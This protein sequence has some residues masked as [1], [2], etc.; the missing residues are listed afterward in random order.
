MIMKQFIIFLLLTLF[1]HAQNY[2][3]LFAQLGTPLYKADKTFIKISKLD[4][5]IKKMT[6]HYHLKVIKLRKLAN[7]IE[8]NPKDSKKDKKRYI[9]ELRQLQKDYDEITR[10]V[11]VYLF[12]SIDA[13]DYKEF[14]HIM[15]IGHDIFLENNIIKKRAM[16]YYV[17][18][19]TR[20]KIPVLD[21]SYLTLKSDPVLYAYVKGYM[22][23]THLI[24][25]RYS[26]GGIAHKVLLSKDQKTAFMG[27]GNYCFKS[28]DIRN[29]TNASQ[30]ASFDFH[31][32]SCELVDMQM[33]ASGKYLFLSDL[34]NGFTV[35]DITQ[36]RAPLQKD[37]WTKVQALC[38]VTSQD[39][40]TSFVVKKDRGLLVLDIYNKDEFRLLANYNKGLQ[41]NHLA[42]DDN[43]SKLY[44]AHSKGL[45]V[46][47]VSVL[48]NP[49]EIYSFPIKNGANHIILDPSKKLAYVASGDDGV[50]VL[51]LSKKDQISLIST[52]LTP[53]YAYHLTLSNSG[54]KLFV[55]ALND[56]VYYI[57]T[58]NSKDLKHVSTYKLD[59]AKA[60]ALSATL[61]AKEDTLFIAYGKLGM[62]KIRLK[63]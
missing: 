50:H 43:N 31:A 6:K 33:S 34:K 1:L 60:S 37:E 18:H 28:I 8:E 38:S 22:P 55:S 3:K 54:E 26:E 62:A 25:Q 30:A 52:C 17:E 48:G 24:K 61:N 59:K 57:D 10:H 53:N 11:N 46:L 49:R 9:N 21:S 7:K 47:D 32:H 20:G 12:K 2:P 5:N 58:K 13:N 36:A 4:A 56:G 29:F 39:D 15:T 35:L 45:S 42:L 16:A 63:E 19:R 27:Y 51:D 44:L 23:T 14:T 40:I 41:I